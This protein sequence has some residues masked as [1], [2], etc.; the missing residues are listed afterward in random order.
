M[1][2]NRLVRTIL[3]FSIVM[4]TL[5]LMLM[6]FSTIRRSNNIYI[7][8]DLETM[9][10]VQLE[11]PQ[12]GDPIAIVDTTLG[13]IRFVL[14]PQYSPNAVKNFTELAESGY[15]DNTYVFN[16]QSGAYSG[17]GTPNKDGSLAEGHDESRERIKRELHQDL[18]PFR[19]AV[20]CV[21]TTI[22]RGLKER[23]LGGGTYYCG[24][25]FNILNSIKFDE[26]VSNE[27]RGYSVSDKLDD[28]FIEKGG[29][30]NFSQQMTIIGQ[31]YKGY[32]V[33]DALASLEA[34]ENGDYRT[35]IEDVM[36]KSVKISTYSSEEEK[37]D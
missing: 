25:R 16:A 5:S 35:P 17:M 15:Y 27:M 23:I 36:I 6:L 9:K 2:S 24:S 12:D 30:P 18:W 1:K 11:E 20:C 29:I 22:E 37:E 7:S 21:N 4:G 28:A 32:D 13:E 8:I 10:L 26:E 14:Y 34:E 19:G 3:I 33:V 31:T